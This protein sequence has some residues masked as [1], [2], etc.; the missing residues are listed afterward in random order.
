MDYVNKPKTINRSRKDQKLAL[1]GKGIEEWL[2]TQSDKLKQSSSLYQAVR[3]VFEKAVQATRNVFNN[4]FKDD[5]KV[6]LTRPLSAQSNLADAIIAASVDYVENN[7]RESPQKGNQ[8]FDKY[9][10]ELDFIEPTVPSVIDGVVEYDGET[11]SQKAQTAWDII[12]RVQGGEMTKGVS[13]PRQ[14]VQ[15]LRKFK[16]TKDAQ[17]LKDIGRSVRLSAAEMFHDSMTPFY[18]LLHRIEDEAFA[19]VKGET[20]VAK[21][22]ANL[23]RAPN[24]RDAILNRFHDKHG[25]KEMYRAVA[26][27]A[28]KHNMNDETAWQLAGQWLT[29]R[30]APTANA[31]FIR[32]MQADLKEAEAAKAQAEESL[33]KAQ[34][35]G[36][37]VEIAN[38]EK[39]Y[40]EEVKKVEKLT[41]HLNG[42]L[43]EVNIEVVQ[44]K[45][46]KTPM[47][48][49]MNNAT[50]K[51]LQKAIEAR[52]NNDTALL[53][54]LADA[55]SR[56]NAH[57][58]ALDIES[59]KVQPSVVL[60]FLEQTTNTELR[61]DMRAL[62]KLGQEGNKGDAEM[63][64]LLDR[65]RDKVAEQVVSDYVPLSGHDKT[66]TE[67]ELFA[68]DRPKGAPNT[69]K[70]FRMEGRTTMPTDGLTTTMAGLIGSATYAG[71][72]DF[73][74]SFAKMYRGLTNAQRD[75]FGIHALDATDR[76]GIPL[77]SI[78]VRRNGKA[79]AFRI[80]DQKA[81][82]ALRKANIEQHSYAMSLLQAPTRLF[83]Y[84]STQAN[85]AFAAKQLLR[86]MFEKTDLLTGKDIYD[87]D[88]R[89]LDSEK[90]ANQ[91]R[92]RVA[93]DLIFNVFNREGLFR[94]AVRFAFGKENKNGANYHETSLRELQN[95]GGLSTYSSMYKANMASVAGLIKRERPSLPARTVKAFSEFI[96]AYNAAAEY[97]TAAAVHEVLKENGVNPKTAA[98]IGLDLMNFRKRGTATPYLSVLY[99]FAQP[100]F[101]GGANLINA[102]ADL[103]KGKIRMSTAYLLAKYTVG[104]HILQTL[105][106]MLGDDDEGGYKLDQA[107]EWRLSSSLPI[108]LPFKDTT[109]NLPLGFGLQRIANAVSR[110]VRDLYTT[111]KGFFEAVLGTT[112]DA[113]IGSVSPIN[114]SSINPQKRPFEFFTMT[115]APTLW[116]PIL[117]VAVNRTSYDTPVVDKRFHKPD[118]YEWDQY[119]KNI[120]PFWKNVAK[121]LHS[122]M[123]VDMA[124]EEVRAVVRGY[125]TGFGSA[126]INELIE[127]P[128]RRSQG[129][130]SGDHIIAPYSALQ[131]DAAIRGQFYLLDEKIDD[132]RKE[133][134]LNPGKYPR[135][136]VERKLMA[137][138]DNWKSVSSSFAAKQREINKISNEDRRRKASYDLRKEKQA[139]YRSFLYLYR[140]ELG[141]HTVRTK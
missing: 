81:F 133:L 135:G 116:Q 91:V 78:M 66:A 6:D 71:Y 14:A 125:L 102:M 59:G 127:Y 110:G 113:T 114:P 136:S 77:N 47:A 7:R 106:A 103:R 89:K 120:A 131:P 95:A 119:G 42:L 90:I 86:D 121:S 107:G 72:V 33:N 55:V 34:A 63:D 79:F 104:F 109:F 44:H 101:T 93:K 20:V 67:E 115:F 19:N 8:Y 2:N 92:A 11:A 111:D 39:A 69:K 124:P 29:A 82:D 53:N 31:R 137:I 64:R 132:Y 38:R 10:Y 98:G 35:K 94:S 70:D 128:Y 5:S 87:D 18:D 23:Q 12:R 84:W 68:T 1:D 130:S 28:R 36:E 52:F 118:M 140:K 99:A 83:G 45:G 75:K 46:A 25:G 37:Q 56:M 80:Q 97:V 3:N 96:S 58:L 129:L 50:A 16:E 138:Q 32:R 21:T 15:S 126:A 13:L 57:R 22:I 112:A 117:S 88:G 74:N 73:G 4:M 9:S 85:P 49:G 141:L 61:D 54:K 41:N 122:T 24:I 51:A 48:A 60:K 76:D 40:D 139:A 62:Q 105:F 108:P 43:M 100:A 65:M 17:H 27:L 123:G 134:K 30:Y 26:E